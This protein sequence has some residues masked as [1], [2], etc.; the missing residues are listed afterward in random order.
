MQPNSQKPLSSSVYNIEMT[1]FYG[2]AATIIEMVIACEVKVR[3]PFWLAQ[4]CSKLHV[5]HDGYN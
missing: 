5:G 1:N 2:W 3:F 4:W